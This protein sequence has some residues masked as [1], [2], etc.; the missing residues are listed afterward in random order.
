LFSVSYERFKILKRNYLSILCN[1]K[2][3]FSLKQRLICSIS[4]LEMNFTYILNRWSTKWT[5]RY[6]SFSS[7]P[8][9]KTK[10]HTSKN[11]S[12]LLFFEQGI[13]LKCP[14]SS[15]PRIQVSTFRTGQFVIISPLIMTEIRKKK[16]YVIF[17]V[18]NLP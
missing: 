15:P 13:S 5:K 12:T 8:R 6:G 16:I 11:K 9:T 1:L 4:F 3:F 2:F 7:T 10:M 17:S 14:I 18:I